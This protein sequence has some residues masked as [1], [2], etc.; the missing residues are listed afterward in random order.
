MDR[1]LAERTVKDFL[2]R[3]DKSYEPL[4]YYAALPLILTPELIHYLRHHFTPQVPFVAEVDLLL[5]DDICQERTFEQYMMHSN[6]RNYLLAEAR[7]NID[8]SQAAGLLMGY[9]RDLERSKSFISLNDLEA[10]AW[11][12]MVYIDEYRGDAVEQIKDAFRRVAHG[13]NI[14]GMATTAEIER[15][16]RLTESISEDLTDYPDLVEYARL[17]KK[18]VRDDADE[19]DLQKAQSLQMQGMP[20]VLEVA[21]VINP[22]TQDRYRSFSKPR[23]FIVPELPPDFVSRTELVGRMVE[24]LQG[25]GRRIIG[26]SGGAGTGKSTLLTALCHSES[27]QAQFMDGILSANLEANPNPSQVIADFIQQISGDQIDATLPVSALTHGLEDVIGPRSILIALDGAS[28]LDQ[29]TP[30]LVREHFNV[31]YAISSRNGELFDQLGLNPADVTRVDNMT[32]SEA[33]ALLTRDLPAEDVEENLDGLQELARLASLHP[34]TLQL[35]NVQL[36]EQTQKGVS[37]DTAIE[38]VTQRL[39]EAE[40][41]ISD[42]DTVEVYFSAHFSRVAQIDASNSLLIYANSSDS[43][44]EIIQDLSNFQDLADQPTRNA[45]Q[46]V[47]LSHG[48]SLTLSIES[49]DIKFEPQTLTKQW[50]S[51]WIRFEFEFR[52][53]IDLAGETIRARVSVLVNGLEIAHIEFACEVIDSSSLDLTNQSD[54]DNPLIA[55]KK[56]GVPSLYSKIYTIYSR[57]DREIVENYRLAQEAVGNDVFVDTYSIRAGENW[58]AA[59]AKAI[60]E[61]DIVQLFWSENAAKSEYVLNEIQY[62]LQIGKDIRPVYWQQPLARIPEEIAHLN[63]SYVPLATEKL[64][65]NKESLISRLSSPDNS[66]ALRAAQQLRETGWLTDGSC[67]KASLPDANLDGADLSNA[68]L[69]GVNLERANLDGA[70]LSGAD[71]SNANLKQSNLD[72][73][74]LRG[75]N[76]TSTDLSEARITTLASFDKKT[77]LPDGNLWTPETDISRFTD[78]NHPIFWTVRKNRILNSNLSAEQT[79]QLISILSPNFDTIENRRAILQVAFADDPRLLDSIQLEGAAIE[80]THRLVTALMRYGLISKDEHAILRLLTV[81]K[82]YVGYA[83]GNEIDSLI[84]T[85]TKPSGTRERKEGDL[86][87]TETKTRFVTPKLLE[88][89]WDTSPFSLRQEVRLDRQSVVDYVLYLNES[90]IALVE[91]KRLGTD[92]QEGIDQAKQYGSVLNLRPIFVTNGDEILQVD[93]NNNRETKLDRFPS[94]ESLLSTLASDVDLQGRDATRNRTYVFGEVIQTASEIESLLLQ[95]L[96]QEGIEVDTNVRGLGRLW[97]DI[98]R[99]PIDIP[100]TYTNRFNRFRELRNQVA[101]SLV[102]NLPSVEEMDETLRDIQ[103]VVKFLQDQLDRR[104]KS[105]DSEFDDQDTSF[106]DTA[107]VTS[108]PHIEWVEIASGSFLMGSDPNRDAMARDNE[109]PQHRVYVSTFYIS[110][111]PITNTQFALFILDG[112]YNDRRYWVDAGWRSK[113]AGR[114][115]KPLYW[116]DPQLNNPNY[117][118]VGISWYEAYAYCRWLSEKLGYQVRLPTEIEWEKAARGTDGRIYSYGDVF[119]PNA[120]NGKEMGIGRPTPVGSYPRSASP[121]GV[122]DMIGNVFDWCSSKWNDAYP[123][124]EDSSL[125]SDAW[126]VIRGGSFMESA[127]TLRVANR[128]HH[129][130]QGRLDDFGFR[131]ACNSP[132]K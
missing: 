80:F 65:P 29:I 1:E 103:V 84:D 2:N 85:I 117:P 64:A 27:V 61:A 22:D 72:G 55:A 124:S 14:S 121:Y 95:L 111:V 20:T 106:F 39:V 67:E 89:G 74:N 90:P 33:V 82:D 68:R 77:I 32:E 92:I 114:W 132:N 41:P 36:R 37:L 118:V 62:A 46:A 58:Q 125:D 53:N 8:V 50:T 3:F 120:Q 45:K 40:T 129:E 83:R 91:A 48:T 119:D 97:T 31:A 35:L 57:E 127:P 47:R 60:D 49:D 94:A 108:K 54:A 104:S 70:N 88:A 12:A 69:S 7:S 59:L 116:D 10:Q 21:S 76:L 81:F 87:E 25:K 128:D 18:F 115:E 23:V 4:L 131:I 52:P 102:E 17:V 73:A 26:I 28:S 44:E 110:Q 30:F 13:K 9:L 56:R 51:D 130:P 122:L 113:Q 5:S 15:L 126:R 71:L 105:S 66:I 24:Q 109:V 96:A 43:A 107:D 38:Q 16:A 99:T 11:S 93:S 100:E 6:I 98:Q 78:A 19:Y 123:L 101:H 86:T 79:N 75:T 63:F 42:A 34:L 112:G